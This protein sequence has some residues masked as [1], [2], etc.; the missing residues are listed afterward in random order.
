MMWSLWCCCHTKSIFSAVLWT[1]R[2]EHPKPPSVFLPLEQMA[3]LKTICS[4]FT[5]EYYELEQRWFP[6]Q[7]TA[8]STKCSQYSRNV[9]DEAT[10]LDNICLFHRVSQGP[11]KNNTLQLL[12]ARSRQSCHVCCF[13][14]NIWKRTWLHRMFYSMLVKWCCQEGINKSIW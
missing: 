3:V 2:S 11:R 4:P 12:R 8:R 1:V 14:S 6:W 5:G 10:V 9:V 7:L 13:S